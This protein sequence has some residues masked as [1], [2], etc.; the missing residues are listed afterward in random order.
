MELNVL[1]HMTWL[2]E[3]RKRHGW[4]LRAE[5]G[6]TSG[7]TLWLLEKFPALGSPEGWLQCLREPVA[8]LYLE[9]VESNL[10]PAY[11]R[12]NLIS[13]HVRLG[14]RFSY[15]NLYAFPKYPMRATCLISLFISSLAVALCDWS[16]WS[17]W[18]PIVCRQQVPLKRRRT[19]HIPQ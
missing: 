1:L 14:C 17:S 9:V 6:L 3:G 15:Q 16:L 11:L 12:S 13:Y 10:Y 7:T 2:T 8:G 19:G 18:L 4:L 5:S